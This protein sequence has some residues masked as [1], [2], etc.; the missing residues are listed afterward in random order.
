[1]R[2]Y[3][4]GIILVNI[5]LQQQVPEEEENAEDMDTGDQD[6][7]IIEREDKEVE[8]GRDKDKA[9]IRRIMEEDDSLH[10]VVSPQFKEFFRLIANGEYKELN[11]YSSIP[12]YDIL[13]KTILHFGVLALA[14]KDQ[15]IFKFNHTRW[16]RN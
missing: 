12:N 11:R 14:F 5:L 4:F 13:I 1:M 7:K 15:D 8:Y 9:F 16:D 6:T 10:D 2:Q 3:L